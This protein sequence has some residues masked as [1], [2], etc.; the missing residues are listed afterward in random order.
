MKATTKEQTMDKTFLHWADENGDMHNEGR[1]FV[2]VPVVG[3]LVTLTSTARCRRVV[4]VIHCPHDP[5]SQYAAEVF[6][7]REEGDAQHAAVKAMVFERP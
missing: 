1:A 4:A 5:P 6:L 2:R 7:G 3:E